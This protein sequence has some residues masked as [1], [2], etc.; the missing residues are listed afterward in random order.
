MATILGNCIYSVCVSSVTQ[1]N[2]TILLIQIKIPLLNSW[3]ITFAVME[4]QLESPREIKVN[5][6]ACDEKAQFGELLQHLKT[7]V[8]T[9]EK[10][11]SKESILYDPSYLDMVRDLKDSKACLSFFFIAPEQFLGFYFK[12]QIPTI[13]LN[14][15]SFYPGPL[16]VCARQNRPFHHESS[17]KPSTNSGPDCC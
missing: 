6:A 7:S 16:A 3:K 9:I 5:M 13:L 15:F 17:Q 12:S 8:E 1:A 11:L 10:I 2:W 4:A 14:F